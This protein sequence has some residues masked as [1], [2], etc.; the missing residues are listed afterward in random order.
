MLDTK[1]NLISVE[2]NALPPDIQKLSKNKLSQQNLYTWSCLPSVRGA[3]ILYFLIMAIFAS[4]GTF[5]IGIYVTSNE[6]H[7]I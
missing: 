1:N 2:S 4:F 5:L 7:I 6:H 3:F